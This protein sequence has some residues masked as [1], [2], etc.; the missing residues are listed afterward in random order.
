MTVRNRPAALDGEKKE[1]K[2]KKPFLVG[3]CGRLHLYIVGPMGCREWKTCPKSG[4]LIGRGRGG[5]GSVVQHFSVS[6]C[7]WCLFGSVCKVASRLRRRLKSRTPPLPSLAVVR[8]CLIAL[9]GIAAG[10]QTRRLPTDGTGSGG[11]W[12]EMLTMD[13]KRHGSRSSSI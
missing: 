8:D 9:G 2:Q 12:R 1:K 13:V 7:L 3:S 10:I 5:D 4:L 6:A 11:G